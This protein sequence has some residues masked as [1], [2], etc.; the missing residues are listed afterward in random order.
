MKKIYLSELLGINLADLE[1]VPPRLFGQLFH[2]RLDL[3]KDK[4]Q[5]L[6]K[7]EDTFVPFTSGL[8]E[9]A[10]GCD[11]LRSEDRQ[12]G[13][14]VTRLYLNKGKGWSKLAATIVLTKIENGEC[15]LNAEVFTSIRELAP[16]APLKPRKLI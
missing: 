1:R 15:V 11:I 7:I 16:L 13:D 2:G 3:A 12:Q 8:L 4:I 5:R 14:P 6:E 10:L 9:A